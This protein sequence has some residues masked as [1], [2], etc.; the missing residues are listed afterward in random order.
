MIVSVLSCAGGQQRPIGKA[1]RVWRLFF[2]VVCVLAAAG[3][4]VADDDELERRHQDAERASRAAISGEFLPL[5]RIV[6]KLRARFPGEIVETELESED[7]HPY[8][9]FHVLQPDG[10]VIEIKVD[11]RS[12]RYLAGATDD[13]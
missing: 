3:T 13:D 9:E 2:S 11:A 10:R 7:G 12:G 4:A 8:Y 5:A 6:T 1:V